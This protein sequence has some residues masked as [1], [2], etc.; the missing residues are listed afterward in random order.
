[1]LPQH[2]KYL[3]AI[4]HAYEVQESSRFFQR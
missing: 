4:I 1:M 3:V 2:Y